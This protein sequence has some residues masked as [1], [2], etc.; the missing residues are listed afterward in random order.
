MILKNSS[1]QRLLWI[2]NN[3]GHH[4]SAIHKWAALHQGGYW[5]T[6]EKKHPGVIQ[7]YDEHKNHGSA[8]RR[9]GNNH[10][11]FKRV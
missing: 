4:G 2:D 6:S 5:R 10:F 9:N 8:Y 1:I 11:S 3:G 7:R